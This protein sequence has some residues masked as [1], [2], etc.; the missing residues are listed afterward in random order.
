M[1]ESK[2]EA[3]RL[4]SVCRRVAELERRNELS[5]LAEI[6][7]S[8]LLDVGNP[9]IAREHKNINELVGKVIANIDIANAENFGSVYR[10]RSHLHP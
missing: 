9:Y 7:R 5:F 6:L 10:H 2:S 8:F 4:P 1:S 3:L